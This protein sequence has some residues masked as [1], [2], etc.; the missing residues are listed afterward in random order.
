MAV[1]P[2]GLKVRAKGNLRNN[3]VYEPNRRLTVVGV[4]ATVRYEVYM[5]TSAVVEVRGA[6]FRE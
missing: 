4:D 1:G 2:H 5:C 3:L 6:L